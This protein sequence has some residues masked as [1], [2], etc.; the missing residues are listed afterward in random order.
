MVGRQPR[1]RARADG[2]AELRRTASPRRCGTGKLF[3]IDLNGQRG[4]KFDQDLVFGHGDLLNAFFLVDLLENGGPD[5]GPAYDGPRHFDYKPSRTED[6]D[7]VWA[8]AAANM[9]DLPAA[10][11]AGRGLPRRPR[12][13]G[14]ARGASGVAELRAADPRPRARRYD[15]LLADRARLR[16]L[17]RRPGRRARLRL[18]AAQP[19]RPRA[20][21]R[22]PLTP[23]LVWWRLARIVDPAEQILGNESV[24]G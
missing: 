8:S 19:A 3:H 1:G 22:R 9:R 21:A 24:S 15:D 14:G 13:A 18:R 23:V 20:P 7:G 5:G 16:G 10:Q 6:I 2:R 17:R 4:I 12:G 11:G